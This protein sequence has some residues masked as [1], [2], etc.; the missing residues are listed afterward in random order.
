MLDEFTN[1][2]VVVHVKEPH[3]I[4]IGRGHGSVWGIHIHTLK[5]RLQKLSILRRHEKMQF[6]NT[7]NGYCSNLNCYR[8]LMNFAE[9]DSHV[10]ASQINL[11]MVTF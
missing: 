11:V 7:E 9:R 3:D 6:Q 4:Y 5:T 10:G 1:D 2:T 8:G